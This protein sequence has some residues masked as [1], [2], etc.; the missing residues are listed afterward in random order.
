MSKIYNLWSWFIGLG[1]G[2]DE[3]G[4]DIWDEDNYI[5][6]C[7]IIF[8]YWEKKFIIEYLWFYFVL[9]NVIKIRYGIFLFEKI[10]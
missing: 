6:I 7:K 9:V 2:G 3:G 1:W 10:L 8:G 5:F 4:G